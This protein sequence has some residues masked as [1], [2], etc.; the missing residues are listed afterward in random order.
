MEQMFSNAVNGSHGIRVW[1]NIHLG[2]AEFFKLNMIWEMDPEFIYSM[3]HAAESI[4]V[5]F[6]WMIALWKILTLDNVM[7]CGDGLVFCVQQEYGNIRP[8]V[9]SL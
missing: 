9:A 3:M 2:W 5:F 6:I 1:K 8:F 7:S 4:S